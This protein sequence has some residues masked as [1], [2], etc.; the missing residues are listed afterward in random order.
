MFYQRGPTLFLVERERVDDPNN[1]MGSPAKLPFKGVTLAGR[2]W[3]NIGCWLGSFMILIRTSVAKEPYSF[4][5]FQEGSG[6]PAA[7]PPL[8]PCMNRMGAV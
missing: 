7:C 3:P 2:W 4:V 8:D 5:F 6:P 1:T